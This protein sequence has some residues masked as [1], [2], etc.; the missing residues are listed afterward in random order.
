MDVGFFFPHFL[1]R[2]EQQERKVEEEETKSIVSLP[3]FRS[4]VFWRSCNV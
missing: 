3:R 4:L 1:A 2:K